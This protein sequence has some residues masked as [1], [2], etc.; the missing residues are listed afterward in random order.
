MCGGA[1]GELVGICGL[2]GGGGRKSK[3]LEEGKYGYI[4]VYQVVYLAIAPVA[5]R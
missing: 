1:W 4:L 2:T 5:W 3:G